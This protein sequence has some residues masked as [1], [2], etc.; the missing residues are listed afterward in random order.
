V[1]T[2]KQRRAYHPRMWNPE[3]VKGIE[4][5]EDRAYDYVLI[6]ICP[7]CKY[8]R[9]VN[10]PQALLK[11]ARGTTLIVDVMKRMRC[12]QCQSRGA[13][14]RIERKPVDRTRGKWH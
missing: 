1:W 2:L 11:Y 9:R 14:H 8:E 7:K 5:L 10:H 4:K 3:W 13:Q 6:V 12:S